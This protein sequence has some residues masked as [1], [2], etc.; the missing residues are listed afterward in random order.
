MD[1]YHVVLYVHLLSLLLGFGA[2]SVILVCL[3]KL[4][5]AH[6]AADAIPWGMLVGQTERVFPIAILGLF[7]SGAY[8]TSKVWTVPRVAAQ[9]IPEP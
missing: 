2:A 3:F 6:T 7:G 5:S 9:A 4:R 1:T 8:M